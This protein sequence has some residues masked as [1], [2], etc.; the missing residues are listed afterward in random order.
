MLCRPMRQK[1]AARQ[2]LERHEES[3]PGRTE[4][5]DKLTWL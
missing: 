3:F 5:R 1:D 2:L 4:F